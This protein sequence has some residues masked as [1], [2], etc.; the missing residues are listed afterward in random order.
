MADY[1]TQCGR[2]GCREFCVTETIDWDGEVDTD[3]LI[4]PRRQRSS[5]SL[6]IG[7]VNQMRA[8]GNPSKNR[9]S[10]S[11]PCHPSNRPDSANSR[12]RRR[13]CPLSSRRFNRSGTS[14]LTND[15][16]PPLYA[17]ATTA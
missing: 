14:G 13:T 4:R 10:N 17:S 15:N 3:L 9:N 1:I 2:C 7:P 5:S 11:I 6:L 16:T 8:L 12:A